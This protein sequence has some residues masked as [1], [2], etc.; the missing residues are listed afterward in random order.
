LALT[1]NINVSKEERVDLHS[2]INIGLILLSRVI[3]EFYYNFKKSHHLLFISLLLSMLLGS[4]FE[5]EELYVS[6]ALILNLNEFVGFSSRVI[7][8]EIGIFGD[9][10]APTYNSK[11][12]YTI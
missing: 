9:E 4:I 3:H 8:F 12:H 10:E 6:L 11:S 5:P 7:L 2:E 1:A